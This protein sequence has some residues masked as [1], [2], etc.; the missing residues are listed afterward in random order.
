ML[1][2]LPTRP[3]ENEHFE[4]SMWEGAKFLLKAEKTN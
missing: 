3:A 4:S 1:I 2:T